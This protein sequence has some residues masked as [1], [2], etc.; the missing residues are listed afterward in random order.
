[1]IG[2]SIALELATRGRQVTILEAESE[3]GRGASWAGAGILPAANRVKATH[4]VEQLRG[5]SYEL[6]AAW[7]SRLREGFGVDNG[8]RQCGGMLL[9]RTAGETA[10]L[11]AWSRALIEE[12]IAC[13]QIPSAQL[14]EFIPGICTDDVRAAVYVP[15]EAQLRNPWHLRGLTQ[16]C[17]QLGVQLHAQQEVKQVETAGRSVVAIST[18]DRRWSVGQMCVTAGAWT[19]RVL[20]PH[21]QVSGIM[22]IRGQMVLFQC[23]ERPFT[24]I[25]S[26]GSRY[27]VPREDGLVLAG[28]CEEEVGFDCATT[29][30]EIDKLCQFAYSWIP[31]LREARIAATWA[32]LRPGSFDG[33]PYLG[34]LPGLD[35]GFVAA[36]HFRHGLSLSTGTA[37]VMADLM[38]DVAPSIDLAAF[39]VDRG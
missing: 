24:P 22:P 30:E 6:H 25:L 2:L 35:N 26:E 5:L 17:R 32:G 36:G 21:A 1:M 29:T 12:D 16:A 37:E 20:A 8:Y 14:A 18:D 4:P 15:T 31:A 3:F 11:L 10:S 38:T 9:A 39:R 19:G 28:S 23:D 13:E 27:L 34:R 33:L 7:S